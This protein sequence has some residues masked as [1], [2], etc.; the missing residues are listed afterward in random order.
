[1]IIFYYLGSSFPSSLPPLPS[2]LPC[3]ARRFCL[4]ALDPGARC[5]TGAYC[6][7]NASA[8]VPCPPGL[9]TAGDGAASAAEC[10]ECDAGVRVG[11][12][13]ADGATVAGAAVAGGLVVRSLAFHTHTNVQRG[14]EGGREGGKERSD[15]IT[16]YMS[17]HCVYVSPT[18][19]HSDTAVCLPACLPVYTHA[20]G[21]VQANNII[22]HL[23][24]YGL[25]FHARFFA[26]ASIILTC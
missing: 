3:P 18:H 15:A 13:C 6:P 21:Y 22:T 26:I 5:P 4:G 2:C 10:T 11:G 19:L 1:M 20:D 9:T 25:Y 16:V 7:P 17:P 12:A 23:P 24:Q 8:P 14:R